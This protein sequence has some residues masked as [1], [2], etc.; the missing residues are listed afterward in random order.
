MA[1]DEHDIEEVHE[2]VERNGR[3]VSWKGGR[4][5]GMETD[6]VMDGTNTKRRS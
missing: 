4:I 2:V 3:L 5:S 6:T 1:R